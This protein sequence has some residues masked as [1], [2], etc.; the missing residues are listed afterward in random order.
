MSEPKSDTG[1]R[2]RL[3]VLA[4]VLL[5]VVALV[6]YVVRRG[7]DGEQAKPIPQAAPDGG[8]TLHVFRKVGAGAEEILSGARVHTGDRLRFKVDLP[9]PGQ[10]SVISV[11]PSGALHV[12][13]PGSPDALTLHQAGDSQP[14]PGATALDATP[15]RETLYLV[16]C[17]GAR[18]VPKCTVDAGAT[19]ICPGECVLTPFVLEKLPE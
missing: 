10:V 11:G 7:G 4:M 2:G 3:I 9:K 13:W 6:F 5:A 18:T 1:S 17:P 15:G 12:A 16:H 8:G 14:L 19:P